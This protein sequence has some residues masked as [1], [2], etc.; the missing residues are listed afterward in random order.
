MTSRRR[1]AAR[2]DVKLEDI[3]ED[4]TYREDEDEDFAP[5]DESDEGDVDLVDEQTLPP[6]P[7]VAEAAEA[8][9]ASALPEKEPEHEAP[10]SSDP[11]EESSDGPS[12][13]KKPK[14]AKKSLEEIMA[15]MKARSSKRSAAAPGPA[16]ATVPAAVAPQPRPAGGLA[17]LAASLG[18]GKKE[19]VFAASQRDWH[20][21]KSSSGAKEDLERAARDGFLS[22]QEFLQRVDH[23]QH[24]Q[25]LG[26]K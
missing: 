13:S 15:E 17:A 11:G 8:P 12:A 2:N 22:R 9:G 14:T 20:A 5:S 6:G 23:K 25:S 7:S 24:E 10:T 4:E 18:K 19:T 16:S 26:R 1:A 21:L 3:P